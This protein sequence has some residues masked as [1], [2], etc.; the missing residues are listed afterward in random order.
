M[1]VK[2][3]MNVA[4]TGVQDDATAEVLKATHQMTLT[5]RRVD[6]TATDEVDG[7]WS[8]LALSLVSA[9]ELNLQSLTDSFG[10][11]LSFQRIAWLAIQNQATQDSAANK[12]VVGGAGAN[13]WEP[14][15]GTVGDIVVVSATGWFVW[16]NTAGATVDATNKILRLDSANTVAIRIMV[17]GTKS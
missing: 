3:T 1:S 7:V 16:G 17:I 8:N 4:F 11:A 9:T 15:V 10:N 6:G 14:F 2:S 13:A 5:E 12:L